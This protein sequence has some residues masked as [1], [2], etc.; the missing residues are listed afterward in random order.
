ML[1]RSLSLTSFLVACMLA[2][3]SPASPLLKQ[4]PPLLW[5]FWIPPQRLA[6]SHLHK[7]H[8]PTLCTSLLKCHFLREPS[9]DHRIQHNLPFSILLSSPCRIWHCRQLVLILLVDL[10]IFCLST[11]I[12]VPLG[13]GSYEIHSLL[14]LH[15]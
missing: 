1:I 15:D 7:I 3:C 11:K 2:H 12:E 9:K 8:A 14:Y 6:P 4:K 13:P 10:F 5:H